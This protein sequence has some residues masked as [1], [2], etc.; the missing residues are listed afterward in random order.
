VLLL[1]IILQHRCLQ[2]PLDLGADI[3]MHSTNTLQDIL[4]LGWSLIE[5][6]DL[7]TQMHFNNLGDIG[8]MDSF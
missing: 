5:G 1:L 4:M 2:N 3:V 7:G 8:P 6:E